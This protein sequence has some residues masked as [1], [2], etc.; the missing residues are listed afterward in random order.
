MK[1]LHGWGCPT[2]KTTRR[3][4]RGKH[5]IALR[6]L[7]S[8]CLYAVLPVFKMMI[9]VLLRCSP[10]NRSSYLKCN[11]LI[12]SDLTFQVPHACFRFDRSL[13]RLQ[14]AGRVG[15]KVRFSFFLFFSFMTTSCPGGPG[16]LRGDAHVY[17]VTER[18]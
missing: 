16:N 3:E 2:V 7:L 17:G 11:R 5:N 12:I 13:F 8:I 10:G 1:A 6:S 14:T 15:S 9:L 4:V 18:L